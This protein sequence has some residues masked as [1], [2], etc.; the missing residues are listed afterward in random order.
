MQ[1]NPDLDP[2]WLLTGN[3]EMIRNS[4]YQITENNPQND[5][6]YYMEIV[7][8]KEEEIKVLKQLIEAKQQLIDQMKGKKK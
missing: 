3:G 2:D 5:R 8:S 1:T 6:P 4:T 7:K